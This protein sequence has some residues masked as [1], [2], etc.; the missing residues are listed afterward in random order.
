MYYDVIGKTIYIALSESFKMT[1]TK[2]VNFKHYNNELFA[3]LFKSSTI[4]FRVFIIS[5]LQ[6]VFELIKTKHNFP[7]VFPYKGTCP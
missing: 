6:W 4:E 1:K 5:H 3:S 7:N 2:T